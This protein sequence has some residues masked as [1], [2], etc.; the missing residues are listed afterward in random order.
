VNDVAIALEHVDLLNRLD[1]LYV[2]LLKSGLELL[3]VG[4]CAL[5][6][7]LDLP[8]GGTLAA[9]DIISQVLFTFALLPLPGSICH[10]L[11]LWTYPIA[12]I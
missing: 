11:E 8:A 2:Q 12:Y 5:V 3:V 1:R 7:L 6:D 4:A 10:A 9:V